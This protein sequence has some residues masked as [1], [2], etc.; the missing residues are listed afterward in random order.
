MTLALRTL[1][2]GKLSFAQN[3]MR[4]HLQVEFSVPVQKFSGQPNSFPVYLRREFPEAAAAQ[5]FVD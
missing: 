3:G 2:G 5:Q 4:R 1:T